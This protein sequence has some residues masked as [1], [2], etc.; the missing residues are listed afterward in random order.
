MRYS[1]TE[2]SGA[3][4]CR[5][6]KAERVKWNNTKIDGWLLNAFSEWTYQNKHRIGFEPRR[7]TIKL[8]RRRTSRTW[9]SAWPLQNR[10]NIYRHSVW[11]VL[12]EMAHIIS[13]PRNGAKPH[14]IKFCRTLDAMIKAFKLFISETGHK[15]DRVEPGQVELKPVIYTHKSK[16]KTRRP[17]RRATLDADLIR[18]IN[19]ILGG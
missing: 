6:P 1:T 8:S 16:P 19:S 11:V 5:T 14:G 2:G 15:L 12:H 7:M 10:V 18:E 4:K 9:G 3:S 13:P 17:S